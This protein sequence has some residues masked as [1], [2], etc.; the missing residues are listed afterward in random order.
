MLAR[1]A[2]LVAATA[3][4]VVGLLGC[5]GDGDDATRTASGTARKAETSAPAPARTTLRHAGATE[6]KVPGDWLAAGEGAVWISSGRKIYRL[7]PASGRRAAAITVPAVACEGMDVGFGSLWTATC[8]KPGLARIDPAHN[9]VADEFRLAVPGSLDGE[10]SIGAGEGGVWLVVDGPKCKACRVAKVDPRTMRVAAQVPVKPGAAGVRVGAG[11]VWVSNPDQDAVQQIDPDTEE[12]IGTYP[13]GRTPRFLAVGEGGVWTLDQLEGS[14]TH[15]DPDTGGEV[16]TVPA[17][18]VGGGGDIATGGGWVWARGTYTLLAE[19]DPETNRVVDQYGPPAGSGSVAVG[20][21]A[22]WVSAHDVETVWR[23]PLR[24][25][26]P[27][28]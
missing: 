1:L 3:L 17:K 8:V 2:I 16:A 18:I 6:T 12:V 28:G 5:G 4:I 9:R 11:S 22:V 10:G 20:F 27:Q 24:N 21:G 7:D 13:V 23:L 26:D 14:I 25:L 15:L 19:I